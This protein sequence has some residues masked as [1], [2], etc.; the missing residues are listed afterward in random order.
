MLA[1]FSTV[2]GELGSATRATAESSSETPTTEVFGRIV[3][4]NLRWRIDA[5]TPWTKEIDNCAESTVAQD[6]GRPKQARRYD[7]ARY[8]QRGERQFEG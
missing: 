4:R 8:S 6:D 7:E 5:N 2:A 1:R 3:I